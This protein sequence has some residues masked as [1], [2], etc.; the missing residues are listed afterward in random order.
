MSLIHYTYLVLPNRMLAPSWW[1][2]LTWVLLHLVFFLPEPPPLSVA[3]LWWLPLL[4]LWLPHSSFVQMPCYISVQLTSLLQ[5]KHL[6]CCLVYLYLQLCN[7][8]RELIITSVCIY[9]PI[10]HHL[11]LCSDWPNIEY[12]G[13]TS[14]IHSKYL[15]YSLLCELTLHHLKVVS[16]W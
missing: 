7:N 16:Y 13:C 12:G 14:Y 1:D 5:W 15:W 11:P 6:M 3:L 9:I 4:P 8:E 2:H 10:M